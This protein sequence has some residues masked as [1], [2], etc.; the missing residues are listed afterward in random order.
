[1]RSVYIHIKYI[2]THDYSMSGTANTVASSQY[3]GFVSK[4]VI[5]EFAA[6]LMEDSHTYAPS[7]NHDVLNVICLTC[8]IISLCIYIYI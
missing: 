1:M 7:C 3:S 2:S 4:W 8:M 6:M 5:S